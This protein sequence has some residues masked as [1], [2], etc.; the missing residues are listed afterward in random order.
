MDDGVWIGAE[1]GGGSWTGMFTGFGNRAGAMT[2]TDATGIGVGGIAIG[3][4]GKRVGFSVGAGPSISPK[5][6][7][8]SNADDTKKTQNETHVSLPTTPLC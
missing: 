3:V 7:P 4:G 2:G 8:Q 5:H 6:P 1:I